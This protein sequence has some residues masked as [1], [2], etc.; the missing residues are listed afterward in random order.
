MG[1]RR[2]EVTEV[3]T[4]TGTTGGSENSDGHPYTIM[5]LNANVLNPSDEI[6]PLGTQ[7]YTFCSVIF[8][9]WLIDFVWRDFWSAGAFRKNAR[10]P[11]PYGS[12]H[13]IEVFRTL[14]S[15][16]LSIVK[17]EADWLMVFIFP[18]LIA[19]AIASIVLISFLFPAYV[20]LSWVWCLLNNLA[21]N[22][23][24]Q[25]RMENT[26]FIVKKSRSDDGNVVLRLYADVHL[27][28]GILVGE[29]DLPDSLGVGD[30]FDVCFGPCESF[31]LFRN[32]KSPEARG[33]GS[34][35]RGET[36]VRDESPV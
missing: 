30:R 8:V 32:S 17:C 11:P 2:C 35:S 21:F 16:C 24:T 26:N 33:S 18:A 4:K 6:R 31:C 7:L 28:S 27:K 19:H 9:P 13:A 20:V 3:T 10:N 25:Q 29:P 5:S 12:S 23:L 15:E 22:L 14:K 36:T 1:Y 34:H